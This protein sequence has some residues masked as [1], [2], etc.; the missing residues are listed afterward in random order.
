MFSNEKKCHSSSIS[1]VFISH[2]KWN[3]HQSILLLIL[4]IFKWNI[5]SSVIWRAA[6]QT[7]I[8]AKN[9]E[10]IVIQRIIGGL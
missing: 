5:L 4:L 9:A 10:V 3:K 8:T 2:L 7:D 6:G 1:D